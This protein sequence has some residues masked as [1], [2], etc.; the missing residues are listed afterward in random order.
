MKVTSRDQRKYYLV[1]HRRLSIKILVLAEITRAVKSLRL[2]CY[3]NK[4]MKLAILSFYFICSLKPSVSRVHIQT[5]LSL[6]YQHYKGAQ[7]YCTFLLFVFSVF[8][9]VPT[10]YNSVSL[11]SHFL[12]FRSDWIRVL[13]KQTATEVGRVAQVVT[14]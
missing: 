1:N 7:A 11:G 8:G 5:T 14:L 3:V 10:G 12:G 6:A 2:K 9:Q 4:R 13:T